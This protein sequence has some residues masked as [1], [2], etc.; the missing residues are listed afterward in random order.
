MDVF[1]T[2]QKKYLS[3]KL[4]G[5]G[6]ARRDIK[7][8]ISP[9]LPRGRCGS[10]PSAADDVLAGVVPPQPHQAARAR[11]VATA[12]LSGVLARVHGL[13]LEDPVLCVPHAQDHGDQARLGRE[14]SVAGE[15]ECLGQLA[16]LTVLSGVDVFLRELAERD[17]RGPSNWVAEVELQPHRLVHARLLD[18]VLEFRAQHLGH[19]AV[20]NEVCEAAPLGEVASQGQLATAEA[21]SGEPLAL[22][23]R[24]DHLYL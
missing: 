13:D 17:G 18:Q 4:T 11:Q 12:E 19:L 5:R 21:G 14:P 23:G 1:S 20:P 7:E 16:D 9:F 8:R 2:H 15:E 6:A 10:P 22:A 3:C 24:H